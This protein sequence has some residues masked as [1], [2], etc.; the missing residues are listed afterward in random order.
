M[1]GY[2]VW[3]LDDV[4]L[5]AASCAPQ[6]TPL[7][8]SSER[9][10]SFSYI[11]CIQQSYHTTKCSR[12]YIAKY[13]MS[14]FEAALPKKVRT[15]KQLLAQCILKLEKTFL[16]SWS[17]RPRVEWTPPR[18]LAVTWWWWGWWCQ[19][20]MMF[21]EWMMALV[22][23]LLVV[24]R[25]LLRSDRDIFCWD[26]LKEKC[27]LLHVYQR[28]LPHRENLALKIARRKYEASENDVLRVDV[29][30]PFCCFWWCAP[31]STVAIFRTLRVGF[32]CIA[33]CFMLIML[34]NLYIWL[35]H[36]F[37][38]EKENIMIQTNLYINIIFVWSIYRKH[39]N[40]WEI[41]L[42]EQ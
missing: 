36:E 16:K 20:D 34:D 41:L 12:S 14:D 8:R 4:V 5:F 17:N 25:F 42:L 6:F 3:G 10:E 27:F 35:K 31:C 23:S 18:L 11:L 37:W 26:R 2:E 22:F 15:A 30:R 24:M 9:N 28:A 40:N 19:M 1:S 21:E 29:A 32:K 38:G 7:F 39:I 13:I 33:G